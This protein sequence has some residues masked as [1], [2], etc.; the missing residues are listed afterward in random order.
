MSVK[1]WPDPTALTVWPAAA[2]AFTD[3][4]SSPS[5]PGRS[6]VSAAHCWLPPQFLQRLAA[7][8]AISVSAARLQGFDQLR[9]DLVDIADHAQVGDREDRGVLVLVDGD[10]VLGTLHANQV[11]RRTGDA[12]GDVDVGLDDLAR[13]THLVGVGHP[14][15]V[16][17]RP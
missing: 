4:T 1:E 10:D 7:T 5:S 6:T 16:D 14:T 17:D 8:T 13:L 15:G 11:L 9:H 12:G 3:A 2:A